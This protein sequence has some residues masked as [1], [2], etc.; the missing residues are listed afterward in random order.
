M[1]RSFIL[2]FLLGLIFEFNSLCAQN[3]LIGQGFGTDDWSTTND[4]N[5][6]A[7]GSRIGTFTANGTGNQYFRTVINWDGNFNQY[8]IT[9]GSDVSVNIETEL[10]PNQ[11]PTT[12]GAMYL[13]V[14]DLSY[15]YI[16]KTE[17]GG[18]SPSHKLIIFQVQGSIRAVSSVTKDKSTVYRG[19]S[20]TVTATLDGAFSTGQSLYLRYSSDNFSSSSV[21][22]MT[23]SEST[24]SAVIPSNVNTPGAN[25]VYYVFTS[26]DGLTISPA[27]ADWY[28]INLNNNSGSNYS[29]T[30]NSSF[31]TKADGNWGTTATWADG[32]PTVGANVIIGNNVTLDQDAN[33]ASLTI[34]NG[35]TFTASDG[36]KADRKLTIADGG[37]L[38]NDGT[39]TANDGTVVFAGSGTVAGSVTFNDVEINGGVDFGNSSTIDGI[40]TVKSNGFANTNAP[41]YS[42]NS[43]LLFDTGGAY[44]INGAADIW[45]IGSTLGQG[46]PNNVT[47]NTTSP[48]NIYEARDVTG[49]LTINSVG[50]VVQGN[51]AFII[52]GDF[53]NSGDFSFVSDGEERLVVQ[54]DLVN[55]TG[56]TITLSNEIGGDMQLEGDYQSD[57]TVTFNNRAI[58]FEGGNSQSVTGNN[59]PINFDYLFIYK[60]ANTEVTFNQNVIVN[61]KYEQSTGNATIASDKTLEI[62]VFAVAD[63]A[64]GSTL[65][66]NGHLVL[67]S[68][69]SGTASLISN[70]TVTGNLTAQRYVDNFPDKAPKWHYVSSP[71]HGQALDASWMSTNSILTNDNGHEFYRWDEDSYYWIYFDYEGNQP[72]DFGDDT[73][74]PAR[75]YSI[76]RDGAGVLNFIGTPRTSN[77][78]YTASYTEDK[79]EGWN[80]VG[81]PF[82]SSIGITSSATSDDYFLSTANSD[83]IDPNYLAVFIWDEQ[84]GYEYGE[85]DFKVI[86]NS[87]VTGYNEIDQEYVEPGQAFMVKVKSP[88]GGTLEFNTNMQTHANVD[89]Y[90]SKEKWPSV[91]LVVKGNGYSNSTAIGFHDEMTD[92]LDPSYDVGKLRG[93]SDVSLYTR[94]V[95]DN[96]VDFAIQALPF[97]GL[98]NAVIQIGV[99]I[100]TPGVYE[101]SASQI[102][103]DNYEIVLEDRQENTLTNLRED[104]Y[105]VQIDEGGLGRFY[106][107]F[108]DATGIEA[109]SVKQPTITLQNNQLAIT[110]L[111]IGKVDLRIIDIMGRVV[112]AESVATVDGR[113][114]LPINLNSGIYILEINTNYHTFAHKISV[115]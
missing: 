74:I 31:I 4:F 78:S 95:A 108:K 71:V 25:I 59:D 3:G 99:D 100:S 55:Q 62:D 7:G 34:N 104:G 13:N 30:V 19:Q 17:N 89:F 2:I 51:N 29:Y 79:G 68:D 97:S 52:Q 93:N 45:I 76:S 1:K 47:V 115:N 109:V 57:G 27:N 94:L 112:A 41:T 8:T 111:E 96:G 64:S 42:S 87:G 56:A 46:V 9:N 81:N 36:S 14:P 20:V 70:G 113:I 66:T 39:F 11:G 18:T 28:T 77:A 91:N 84:S 69:A 61:D 90:K 16:F 83:V 5:A 22:E 44:T 6:S 105:F 63:I 10:N 38:T 107:H 86:S 12:S 88:S 102:N 24:Y 92:G 65:T 54:G 82:T 43:T 67:K 32:I 23:G 35:A 80:L 72:E 37:T 73:F 40:L 49:N 98:E 48:L 106:L 110:N 53:N 85:D 60:D 114:E 75:G 15:N 50:S 33:V 21:I 103:F 101:F 58:F 26:G